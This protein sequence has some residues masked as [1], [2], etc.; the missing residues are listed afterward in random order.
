MMP[1]SERLRATSWAQRLVLACAAAALVLSLRLWIGS[2]WTDPRVYVV[3]LGL[4]S[5]W[6][7]SAAALLLAG[8]ALL[9][10][11]QRRPR[12]LASSSL[13]WQVTTWAGASVALAMAV[14]LTL[15]FSEDQLVYGLLAAVITVL[16][17]RRREQRVLTLP[18]VLVP[19]AFVV[20]GVQ[21]PR[22]HGLYSLSWNRWTSDAS[23]SWQGGQN[24][25]GVSMGERPAAIAAYRPHPVVVPAIGGSLGELVSKELGRP[26]FDE[27]LRPD[28]VTIDVWGNLD[29]GDLP[30]YLPIV[31]SDTM[32]GTLHVDAKFV[33]QGRGEEIWSL[34]CSDSH[35]LSFTIDVSSTGISSCRD[36]GIAAARSIAEQ[37]RGHARTL[38]GHAP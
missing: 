38:S 20:L 32:R 31:S 34:Q 5:A 10:R 16:A 27:L 33:T 9:E 18:A 12:G 37:I 25:T 24:C 2:G 14:Q 36:L 11:L 29:H 21:A 3:Q 13:P 17:W 23:W 1:P 8:L 22:E 15:E 35:T 4:A 7:A 30:C 6:G 19:C 28:I 26:P